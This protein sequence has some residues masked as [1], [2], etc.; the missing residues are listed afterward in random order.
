MMLRT[1]LVLMWRTRL[2][3]SFA[4]FEANLV[5]LQ[6]GW[7]KNVIEKDKHDMRQ[8]REACP[9]EVRAKTF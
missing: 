4:S 3:V 5:Q 9:E 6:G 7:Q 2:E 8:L 1:S